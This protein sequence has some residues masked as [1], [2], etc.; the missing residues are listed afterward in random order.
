ML[1][2]TLTIELSVVAATATPCF[3]ITTYLMI[4]VPGPAIAGL[5]VFPETPDQLNVP[6]AVPVTV[7]VT[8]GSLEQYDVAKPVKAGSGKIFNRAG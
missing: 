1:T 3:A 2:V 6:P 4:C 8:A 5:K 7:N